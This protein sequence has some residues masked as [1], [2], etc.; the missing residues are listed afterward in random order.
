MFSIHAIMHASVIHSQFNTSKSCA[1]WSSPR[2]HEEVPNKLQQFLYFQIP[3]V[4]RDLM[5][6]GFAFRLGSPGTNFICQ[7]AANVSGTKR[8]QNMWHELLPRTG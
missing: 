4:P 2:L 8:F 3:L 1:S 7:D 6:L 5:R